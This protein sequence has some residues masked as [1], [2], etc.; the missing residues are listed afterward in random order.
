MLHHC[1]FD[2]VLLFLLLALLIV[3]LILENFHLLAVLLLDGLGLG[4]VITGSRHRL[5]LVLLHLA[6]LRLDLLNSLSPRVL[7]QL[8][9]VALDLVNVLLHGG[10]Q[11]LF[12]FEAGRTT[13]LSV[14]LLGDR[15]VAFLD[16]TW[17]L[18]ISVIASVDNLLL[19][20]CS[21]FIPVFLRGA[22]GR[23]R[24]CSLAIRVCGEVILE[25]RSQFVHK[26]VLDFLCVRYNSLLTRFGLPG[27]YS[28]HGHRL[29][30]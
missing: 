12:F 29:N 23:L 25:L 19:C 6:H 21:R 22:G 10:K 5:T 28:R 7:Q 3:Q 20:P 4:G 15:L 1:F 16:L 14:G 27:F 17:C 26:L 8:A 9:Q 11:L 30:N 2:I 18:S 13:G 24:R